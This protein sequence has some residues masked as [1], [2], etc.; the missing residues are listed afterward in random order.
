MILYVLKIREKNWR[1]SNY[2]NSLYIEKSI[3]NIIHNI[4]NHNVES[5]FTCLCGDCDINKDLCKNVINGSY[6]SNIYYNKLD[7]AT[8]I[9]GLHN[10][11]LYMEDCIEYKDDVN[12]TCY[13]WTQAIDTDDDVPLHALHNY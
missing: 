3:E 7:L 11:T 12:E 1:G 5:S 10:N 13:L 6:C 9:L 2:I 4:L 8:I